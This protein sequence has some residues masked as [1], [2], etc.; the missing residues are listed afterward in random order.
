MVATEI[1]T[2]G[3]LLQDRAARTPDRNAFVFQSWRLDEPDEETLTCA[4]LLARSRAVAAALQ[5]RCR[6]RDRALIL[7]PPGLGYIVAFFACQLAGV[8]AVPAYPPRNAGH[9][10]RLRTIIEDADASAI[11]TLGTW[12]GR[13]CAPPSGRPSPGTTRWSLMRWC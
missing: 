5:A 9:M 1:S 13:P 11:L 12:P 7:C 10:A 6:P 3:A 2:L 4:S 8:V